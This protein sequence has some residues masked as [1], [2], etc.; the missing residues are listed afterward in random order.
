MNLI[1]GVFGLIYPIFDKSHN[2]V[3]STT[4]GCR[5]PETKTDIIFGIYR[6]VGIIRKG[7]I[8]KALDLSGKRWN[9]PE[10]NLPSHK[11][12]IIRKK[13]LKLPLSK[14][15]LVTTKTYFRT[16]NRPKGESGACVGNVRAHYEHIDYLRT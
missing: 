15:L 8:R 11:I 14:K 6:G 4:S 7:I 13:I 12:G 1:F 16:K 3:F 10:K 2:S 9:Y 5:S